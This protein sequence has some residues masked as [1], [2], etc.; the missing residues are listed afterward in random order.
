M[1]IEWKSHLPNLLDEVM[2][3]P[4][5]NILRVPIDI[6]KGL[7]HRL[8]GRASEIDDPGLNICMLRLA[9]YD[10]PPLSIQEEIEKEKRRM[11]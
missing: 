11:R 6:T 5:C 4:T 10:V 8:A 9:L 1:D 3:N 7:L 2:N